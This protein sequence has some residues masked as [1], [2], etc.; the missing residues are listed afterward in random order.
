MDPKMDERLD[1]VLIV[2][3][4]AK[5]AAFERIQNEVKVLFGQAVERWAKELP[6]S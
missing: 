1:Y 2:P 3:P 6:F 5:E 4:A